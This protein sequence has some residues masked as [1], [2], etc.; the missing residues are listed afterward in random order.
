MSLNRPNTMDGGSDD[1]CPV[2]ATSIVQ[3]ARRRGQQFASLLKIGEPINVTCSNGHN[4]QMLIR[5]MG[6]CPLSP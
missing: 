1:D 3:L 2:K 5:E 4:R 6:K